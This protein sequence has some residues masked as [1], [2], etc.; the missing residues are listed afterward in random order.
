MTDVVR[1]PAVAGYFYPSDPAALRGELASFSRG[2]PPAR[3]NAHAVVV[4]HGSYRRSGAI[5]GAALARTVIPRQCVI[6]GPSHTGS[7]MPWSVMAEGAYRTPLGDVPVN[8]WMAQA[9]R[10]RCPFLEADAWAQRGEHAI[11]VV[12]PF[13]QWLGPPDLTVVPVIIGSD[14]EAEFARL[15]GA[16][17]EVIRMAEEP[18]LMI[19]SSDLSHYEPQADAAAH[20]RRLLEA[21]R[22]LD[23]RAVVR[24]VQEGVRMCGYGA[25]ACAIDAATKLGASRATVVAHQT[26]A[27]AGGDPHSV[28][29]YA[30]VVIT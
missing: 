24:Q 20:D 2:A 17:A 14:D 5:V 9:L 3:A 27:E 16:L 6:L 7:W 26:S 1:R 23:Y 19:A 12:L 21:I 22:A 13:L 4:P 10:T 8:G 11:E 25:V 30:G 18:V 28:I 15:A 29:G